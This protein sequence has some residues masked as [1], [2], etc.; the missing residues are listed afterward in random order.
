MELQEHRKE[1][2]YKVGRNLLRFQQMEKLL[3]YLVSH[4]TMSGHQSELLS[5][6]DRRKQSVSKSTLGMNVGEFLSDAESTPP[7]EN[8]TEAHF[9]F[10][11]DFEIEEEM[12]SKIEYLV[13]ER[14]YLVHHFLEDIDTET[15]ASWEAASDRLD[16]QEEKLQEAT[17]YLRRLA[18]ALSEGRRAIA[19]HMLTEEFRRQLK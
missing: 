8:L 11:F 7:P 9:E 2:I 10:N 6:F 14:N 18:E 5:K 1:V 16:Q 13:E 12:K 15:L 3:K 19:D 4:G 17:D